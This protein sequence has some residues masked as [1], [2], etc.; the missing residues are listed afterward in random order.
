MHP[1][2]EA[3]Q[4]K[5]KARPVTPED[6]RRYI[7]S[8]L[9]ARGRRA[10]HSE[11]ASIEQPIF[12]QLT[13]QTTTAATLRLDD[14]L[15]QHTFPVT[16]HDVHRTPWPGDA[17]FA[18]ALSHDVDFVTSRAQHLYVFRR[19]HRLV[20][21]AGPKTDGIMKF[22]GSLYRLLTE[23]RPIERYGDLAD[24][25][26][27][28]ER[29]GVRSTF[30]FLPYGDGGLHINDGDYRFQDKI[31]FNNRKVAVTDAIRE[32]A[33][34]GWE[35][36]L[37]GTILSATQPG[38][39]TAQK[40]MLESIIRM[41]IMS[42]RQHYLAY[43]PNRT[44]HLF[45]LAG[46]RFDSTHGLNRDWGFPT[47]TAHPYPLWDSELSQPLSIL[48]LPLAIMDTAMGLPEKRESDRSAIIGLLDEMISCTA[49]HNGVLVL[50][51]HPNYWTMGISR[52]LYEYALQTSVEKG[53]YIDCLKNVGSYFSSFSKTNTHN[54]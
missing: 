48:E 49:R 5:P 15:E 26:K 46:I 22:L 34:S 31:V 4:V 18:V 33:A 54:A 10:E 11:I 20:R 1:P 9:A 37:H 36:G 21:G 17:P 3:H 2:V 19:L 25:M 14:W 47:G 42:V 23:I 13:R 45:H 24:W 30:F 50:N 16:V 28:E 40:R 12:Q 29:Y 51:W 43:D 39:L 35:I 53:A 6:I 7:G 41:P 8:W 32:I 44:P 52:T 27:L 38:L